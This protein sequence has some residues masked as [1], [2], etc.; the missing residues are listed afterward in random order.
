MYTL[1]DPDRNASWSAEDADASAFRY[2]E[3]LFGTTPPPELVPG[4]PNEPGTQ[5]ITLRGATGGTVTVH[6]TQAGA[7]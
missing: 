5:R 4:P 6:V 7:T 1:H 3:R 2:A